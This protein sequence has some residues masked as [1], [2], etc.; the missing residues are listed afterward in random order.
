M[1][2]QCVYN[3]ENVMFQVSQTTRLRP[4]SADDHFNSDRALQYV[5]FSFKDKVCI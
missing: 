3:R 4:V 1:T 2:M 5:T